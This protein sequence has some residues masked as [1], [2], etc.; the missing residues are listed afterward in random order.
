[1]NLLDTA[2]KSVIE[3]LP[4]SFCETERQKHCYRLI[5]GEKRSLRV[6]IEMIESGIKI[7]NEPSKKIA[8]DY[9]IS[10]GQKVYAHYLNDIFFTLH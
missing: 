10:L 7:L 8:L 6:L 2:K 4:A 9:C 1:M 5:K 3:E